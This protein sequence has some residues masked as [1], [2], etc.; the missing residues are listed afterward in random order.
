MLEDDMKTP[1]KKKGFDPDEDS[2][3]AWISQRPYA[4]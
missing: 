4:V 1:L 3:A 2:E